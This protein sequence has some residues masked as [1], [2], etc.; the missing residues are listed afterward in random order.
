MKEILWKSLVASLQSGDCVLVLGSE[1][2]AIREEGHTCAETEA[3]S[4]RDTF[5][6][7]LAEQLQQENQEVGEPVLFATAQQFQDSP[8]FSTVNLK[9]IAADFFRESRS[10][11]GPLHVELARCPFSLVL[12]TCHDDLF[13]KALIL[14]GKTPSRYWYHYRGEP[15]DN[16]ELEGKPEPDSP[17]V[18]HLFGAFD[19]PNSLVL[20]ENDLLDFYI[21]LLSGRPKL[22]DSVRSILRDKTFLF[23][24]FGIRH[25][26]IRVLL[27]LFI[28]SLEISA[29]SVALESLGELDPQEREQTVL[30]YRRGTRVEVVDMEAMAFV[31]KLLMRFERSGGYLGPTKRRIRRAQI[32]ISYERSDEKV[33][34]R[35]S[36]VLPKEQFESWLDTDFL[37]GGEDWNAQLEDK[38][39]NS[40][41]FLVLNSENLV[42]KKVGYVNKEIEM[43]LDL[44][45]YRQRGT[46]FIIPLR[47]GGIAV[48]DGR[49]DLLSFQQMPL[50]PE[51]FDD[52]VAQI[53]KTISRA[54]QLRER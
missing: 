9:N 54:F 52:D 34:K 31:Q 12:T 6:K 25:W 36:E 10:S 11:P 37:K 53:V 29:G 4:L 14:K 15:R 22:P 19:E 49:Q 24:G 3:S 39:R 20:T 16:R 2:P 8:A 43:A 38:L 41:Y 33:A 13:T 51:S 50:R 17:V 27:K 21:N 1:I 35:L 45:K 42:N 47:V 40:D 30:F 7:Y 44:Q 26:Y 18:Y 46:K 23:V 32:F 5:C 28:R 48:E